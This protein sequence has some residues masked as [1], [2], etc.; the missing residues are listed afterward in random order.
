MGAFRRRT[1]PWSTSK[2]GVMKT[3]RSGACTKDKQPKSTRL[4]S[5]VLLLPG[6]NWY[7]VCLSFIN[8]GSCEVRRHSGSSAYLV[9]LITETPTDV[10][11]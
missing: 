4:N 10:A 2:L 8:V 5:L 1:G 11:Y 9:G 7:S 6:Y 3:A